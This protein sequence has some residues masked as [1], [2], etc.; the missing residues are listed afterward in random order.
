MRC[1]DE[2]A[3]QN[4]LGFTFSFIVENGS[5]KLE[6]SCV[7]HIWLLIWPVNGDDDDGVADDNSHNFSKDHKTYTFLFKFH[8]RLLDNRAGK[9]MANN[10]HRNTN[11]EREREKK[12]HSVMR[13]NENVFSSKISFS[14]RSKIRNC[15]RE[16]SQQPKIHSPS[17]LER[18]N[19]KASKQNANIV[20]LAKHSK[21]GGMSETR[22][23]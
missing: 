14:I 1:E 4:V 8:Y 15:D 16:N 3:I 6:K 23:C 10:A 22:Q 21:S 17:K 12:N 9:K 7:C 2:F 11:M 19:K 18:L 20:K 5:L 13:Q